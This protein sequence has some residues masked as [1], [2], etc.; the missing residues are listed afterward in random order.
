MN[1]LNGQTW[2]FIKK[3]KEIKFATSVTIKLFL[4]LPQLSR[5]LSGFYNV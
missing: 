3:M 1:E 5:R 4:N 2:D